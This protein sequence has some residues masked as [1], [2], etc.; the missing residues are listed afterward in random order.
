VTT[1]I[2]LSS[3]KPPEGSP[4]NGCG[5]CCQEE[6][7]YLSR[8]FLGSEA[9]PCIALEFDGARYLCGLVRNP[10]RYL[11]PDWFRRSREKAAGY[12]T[13]DDWRRAALDESIGSTFAEVLGCGQGYCSN[14]RAV[15]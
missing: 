2:L 4:C 8:D 13:E 15:T 7:C 6:A 14:T 5:A 10:T 12:L 1:F 3:Q 11:P 9:A